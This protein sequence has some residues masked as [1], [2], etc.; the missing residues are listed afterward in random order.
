M[1]HVFSETLDFL[2]V[3]KNQRLS[4]LCKLIRMLSNSILLENMGISLQNMKTFDF[5]SIAIE[6]WIS[7]KKWIQKLKNLAET[8][9]RKTQLEWC[10]H[11]SS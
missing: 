9:F 5:L 6:F 8:F 10:Q 2:A 7:Q 3:A 4:Y 1:K 11:I